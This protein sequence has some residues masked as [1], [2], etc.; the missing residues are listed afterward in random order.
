MRR[1]LLLAIF[2][3]LLNPGVRA[4]GTGISYQGRILKPDGSPLEG[5]SVQFRL[6]VRSPG[7]ENCLLYDEMKVIDMAGSAGSFALTLNDG[8]GT[9]LDTAT[10]PVSRI[11]ANRETLTLDSTRCATG[12]TYTPAAT[13]GR[14]FVVYF[15]DETM[16][17]FEPLPILNLN[18]VPQSL[19]ALEAQKVGV[20]ASDNILRTVDGSGNPT[21]APA[22]D[23]TQLANLTSLLSTGPTPPAYSAITGATSTNSIDNLN[24]SQ[25]WNWSTATTQSPMAVT[26]NALTTGSLVSVTTSNASLNSTNGLLNIANTGVSTSGI[27]ARFQANSTLGSGLSIL[28]NGSVGIGTTTPAQK[29]D[30]VGQIHASGDICTDSGGGKCLSTAGGSSLLGLTTLAPSYNSFLGATAGAATTTADQNTLIGFG[31]GALIQDGGTNT[32][33]GASALAAT[34]S[35]QA[36]TAVGHKA[37]N[38]MSSGTYNSALG[39][40]SMK[41]T[42]S[43]TYNVAI[44]TNSLYNNISGD[45]NTA[46]GDRALNGVTTGIRNVA[47]GHA[48][49]N[50]NQAGQNNVYIGDIAG[51]GKTSGDSNV[52]I[53][54]S[55][56]YN[57]LTGDRNVFIGSHAGENESGSDKLYIANTNTTTPLI[58]GNFNTEQVAIG[59]NNP[60]A[61]FQVN[62]D[63][64]TGPITVGSQG[65]MIDAMGTCKTGT[66]TITNAEASYACSGVPGDDIVIHCSGT[67]AM[68][69]PGSNG[70]YCRASGTNGQMTCNTLL[71]N[72]VAMKWICMWMYI[73]PAT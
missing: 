10:Y 36:N 41:F 45:H 15:K 70:I 9:R 25:I 58:Y 44:G 59:I 42:T 4:A 40:G 13:D 29:L 5:S 6:Q 30:V 47:V 23:P 2:I 20:F 52:F 8:T 19:Y 43:G 64:K 18:Y 46:V 68:T 73:A 24:Y 60:T 51:Y 34:V 55:A 65:T 61:K 48:A 50:S 38:A 27:L 37:L 54:D 22:L 66:V 39:A 32:A 53:G 17:A 7:S 11:F 1:H 35:S 3:L 49:G 72:V 14:K 69:N 12:T 67:A 57:N 62:G 71:T 33:V 21:T 56:G 26:A 16:S 31:A 28:T 63:V